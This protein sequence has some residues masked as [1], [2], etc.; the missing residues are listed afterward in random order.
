METLEGRTWLT[1]IYFSLLPFI[2]YIL[3]A[4][5]NAI[6]LFYFVQFMVALALII[7]AEVVIIVVFVEYPDTVIFT[8]RRSDRF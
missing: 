5:I 1:V 8:A 6:V 3:N 7:A 2:T 4:T